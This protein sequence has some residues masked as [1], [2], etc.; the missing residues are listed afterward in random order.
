MSYSW[1]VSYIVK[2]ECIID[3]D[4]IEIPWADLSTYQGTIPVNWSS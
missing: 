4:R 1:A 2:I 3:L